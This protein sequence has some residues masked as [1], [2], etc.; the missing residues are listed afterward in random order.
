M[1]FLLFCQRQV[2]A[3]ARM[4]TSPREKALRGKRGRRQRHLQPLQTPSEDVRERLC[5]IGG[6]IPRG[7]RLHLQTTQICW[8]PGSPIPHLN[9][10]TWIVTTCAVKFPDLPAAPVPNPSPEQHQI[11]IHT[12]CCKLP[13][14]AGCPHPPIPHLEYTPWISTSLAGTLANTTEVQGRSCGGAKGL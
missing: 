12:L 13:R 5:I 8:L 1:S 9:N 14:S 4:D 2:G 3:N 7:K 10:T 6:V 11:D